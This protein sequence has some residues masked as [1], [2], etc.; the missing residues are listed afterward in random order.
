[1]APYFVGMDLGGSGTRAALVDVDGNLLADEASG[2][3][4]GRE[5]IAAL[6]RGRDGRDSAGA[7]T[8]LVRGALGR[9]A[10]SV[11]DVIAWVNSGDGQVTRLASLAPLVARA[12]DAGDAQA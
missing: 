8:D 10:Q 3:W 6:L 2:Y 4:L 11:P 9:G 5:A 1:M 12:A 7:L